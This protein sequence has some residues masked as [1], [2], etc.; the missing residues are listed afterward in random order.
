MAFSVGSLLHLCNYH[1]N[2]LLLLYKMK[3]NLCL[4]DKYCKNVISK[5]NVLLSNSYILIFSEKLANKKKRK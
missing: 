2:K 4:S 5:T 1:I 3:Y